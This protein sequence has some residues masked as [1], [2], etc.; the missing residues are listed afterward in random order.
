MKARTLTLIAASLLLTAGLS[1]QDKQVKK[2]SMQYSPITCIKGGE[3]PLLQ[4]NIEGDGELRSYFRRLNS[5]DWCSVEGTNDGP[6]SRVVLPKFEAGDEIEYFFVLIE[7]RRVVAR[8]PHIYR[9]RVNAECN[10]PFA[11]HIMQLALSCGDEAQAIPAATAAGYSVSETLVVTD[12][13]PISEDTPN[14]Q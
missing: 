10:L 9:A 3:L 13:A 8:S 12:P 7:G 6:L 11:R 1:A 14:G 5:T 2:A 4:V